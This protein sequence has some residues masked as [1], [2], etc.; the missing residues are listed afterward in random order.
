M[1]KFLRK[2]EGEG[3]AQAGSGS[4]AGATGGASGENSKRGHFSLFR[5]SIPSLCIY[6]QAPEVVTMCVDAYFF[7]THDSEKYHFT[8]TFY[9]LLK[10]RARL[11]RVLKR[12]LF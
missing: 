3:G 9:A 2:G 4:S 7:S 8:E 11:L 1:L 6:S 12:S 5:V 10:R